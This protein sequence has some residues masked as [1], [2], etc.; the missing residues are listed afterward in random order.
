MKQ[1]AAKLRAERAIASVNQL[2]ALGFRYAVGGWWPW[3]IDYFWLIQAPLN[4][5]NVIYQFAVLTHLLVQNEDPSN[6][7]L[8][9]VK[10]LHYS[11]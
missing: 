5:F 4:F 10:T 7:G 3:I 9:A 11:I 6:T 8:E 1:V 2:Q